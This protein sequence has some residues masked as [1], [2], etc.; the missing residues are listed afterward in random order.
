MSD[1]RFRPQYRL[2]RQA[3]FE[4]V[5]ARRRSAADGRL[6]VYGCENELSWSRLG[7]SVSR[8][9]GG[10]VIR[11]RVKRLIREAFRLHRHELPNS[12]DFI[13]IPRP[14]D[15]CLQSVVESLVGLAASVARK[16][17]RERRSRATS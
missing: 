13:V 5:Y 2:K 3:D 16:L 12:I 8:R 10:S 15:L 14:S 17:E 4:R 11:N 7:L 9:V 1:F 6:V